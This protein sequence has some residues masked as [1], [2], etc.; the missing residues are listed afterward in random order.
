[1]RVF[2][3]IFSDA[4]AM[5]SAWWLASRLGTPL[6]SPWHISNNLAFL[7]LILL[8]GV[9]IIGARGLYKAGGCRRDYFGL[10]KSISLA[11]IILLLIAFLNEP[12]N[13][14]SRSTFLLSWVLSLLF[15]SSSRWSVDAVTNSVRSRGAIR[16]PVFLISEVES[17]QRNL[18][19]IAK[20]NCY[21][22]VGVEDARSLDRG[23][24]DQTLA[25][26]RQLDVVEAFVAWGAIKN[27]LHL[28]WLFQ[29]AGITLRILPDEWNSYFPKTEFHLL[30]DVPAP[31]V[32]VPVIVG[33]DYLIKRA[34]DFCCSAIAILML[35]PIYLA[36]ALFIKLDS[37]GPIFF[38]QTRIGLHGRQFK[39]W[40]F[41]TMVAD[42]DQLQAKLE[43]QNEMKDGVL[44]K[45]K[46][47]PRI[48]NIGSFLRRYSLDELP[49]LF[50]VLLGE[51]SFVGPRP[52]PLR[53]VE[54]FRER[55]FIRQEV[56][57]GITGLWQV[58]GRSNIDNF[59][60]AINL[61]LSYIA[62]WSLW[63]D[64]KILAQTVQVVLHRE[65]AY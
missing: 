4:I 38:R 18:D 40:K 58:S 25:T 44:F 10:F 3:L 39:V 30:G 51:M 32:R 11:Q 63:M 14:F 8:V 65:G 41:R 13:A 64:L 33:S 1:L 57:P 34:F 46:D 27:R 24:R 62:N 42:A 55:Y 20:E 36:V 47:D 61:D 59:E 21:S 52:L 54:R 9:S 37:K 56:L 12:Q 6:S 2:T 29:G 22:L 53:D 43:A 60:D 49:Q 15:V 35:S 19:L 28:C 26:L 31:T 23:R 48:T 7:P 17:R 16:Y 5:S 45:M 50:N